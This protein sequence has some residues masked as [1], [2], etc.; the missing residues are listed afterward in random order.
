VEEGVYVFDADLLSR[1]LRSC[2]SSYFVSEFCELSRGVLSE[3]QGITSGSLG[4][5]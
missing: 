4:E 2:F 5:R 3:L 1:Y